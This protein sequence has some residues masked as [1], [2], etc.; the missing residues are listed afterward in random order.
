MDESSNNSAWYKI[1]CLA[2]VVL[3]L[4]LNEWTLAW[5]FSADGN[6]SRSD[7]RFGIWAMDFLLIAIGLGSLGIGKRRLGVW[8]FAFWFLALVVPSLA[9]L[10]FRAAWWISFS[11]LQEPAFYASP[12]RDDYWKLLALSGKDKAL[13][14]VGQKKLTKDPLL[15]WAPEKT[16]DNPLGLVSSKSFRADVGAR[17]L[18]FYGDSF[19]EGSE[20]PDDASIPFIVR[21]L[22]GI[23]TYNFAVRGYG[24]DQIY[25]R[26]RESARDFRNATAI[27][28]ILMNDLDRV[29]LTFRVHMKPYFEIVDDAL[30]LHT[31]HLNLSQ[32]EF[33]RQNSPKITSYFLR[34]ISRY[35][36][37]SPLWEKEP[38]N[39]VQQISAMIL[40]DLARQSREWGQAILVLPLYDATDLAET[41][42]RETFLKSELKKNGIHY[43]D[44]K[45]A[46]KKEADRSPAGVSAYFLPSG[47]YNRL[48]N[49]LIAWEIVKSQAQRRN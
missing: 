15:G 22:S 39:S 4:L 42:W 26:Y 36:P 29:A 24:L 49:Q 18:L 47:H 23:N 9:E 32:E 41:G 12:S 7:L 35:F 38:V 28:G 13:Q 37:T 20:T 16:P 14:I 45:G 46:L 25:L 3:G 8:H 2:F 5:C 11:P 31:E 44:I 19:M 43:L 1:S 27:I 21:N 48:A 17:S 10:S 6:I 33:L 34:F 30:K 40:R